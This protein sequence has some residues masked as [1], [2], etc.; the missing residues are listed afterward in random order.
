[1]FVLRKLCSGTRVKQKNN[2][3]MPLFSYYLIFDFKKLQIRQDPEKPDIF[4]RFFKRNQEMNNN[5]DFQQIISVH[6]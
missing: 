6:L 1:M 5:L 2:V 3:F 4:V